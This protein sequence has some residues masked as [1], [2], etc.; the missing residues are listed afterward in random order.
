MGREVGSI[1]NGAVLRVREDRVK[2]EA[3]D[4]NAK[5]VLEDRGSDTATALNWNLKSM[6][7]TASG[8]AGMGHISQRWEKRARN[9]SVTSFWMNIEFLFEYRVFMN[10]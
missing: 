7:R 8:W 4:D 3:V 10:R 1:E 6:P 9:R 5:F 2:K